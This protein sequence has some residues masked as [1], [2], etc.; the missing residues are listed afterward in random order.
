ML[1]T[2]K[3]LLP[4]SYTVRDRRFWMNCVGLGTMKEWQRV[5]IT[6]NIWQHQACKISL[7]HLMLH[8][9]RTE[10]K[11]VYFVEDVQESHSLR[12]EATS[13]VTSGSFSLFSILWALCRHLTSPLSPMLCRWMVHPLQSL[14]VLGRAPT[15]Q[16]VSPQNLITGNQDSVQETVA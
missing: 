13:A 3:L 5:E 10:T 4:K 7:N 11:A 9:K 1:K 15:R 12:P 2:P 16:H 14:P 6:E 8:H